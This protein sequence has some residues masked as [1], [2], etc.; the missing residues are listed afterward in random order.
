MSYPASPEFSAINVKSTTSNIKSET[1]S[2]RIQVR[3]IGAQKWSFTAKYNDLTRDEFAPV[4]AFTMTL[5]GQLNSFDIIPPIISQT[6][7][8]ATGTVLA[9]GVHVIGDKTITVDG[10]TGTIKAGD[11]VK[12]N[13][14]SKVYMVTADRTGAGTLTIEPGLLSGVN[15]NEQIIY[16]DVPFKMRLTNDVQQFGLSGFDKY[17]YE[18]DMIEVI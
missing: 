11:F 5:G 14:H 13:G 16:N 1:R 2:G 3:S 10:L 18:I 17:A 4:Y 8:N 15:N 6:S 9:N 12:F 7:G